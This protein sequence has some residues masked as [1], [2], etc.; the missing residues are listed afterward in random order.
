MCQTILISLIFVLT[1]GA[2]GPTNYANSG[3]GYS[4][5]VN[6]LLCLT[7]SLLFDS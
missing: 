7:A 1:F 3:K 5:V 4:G 6:G 2:F